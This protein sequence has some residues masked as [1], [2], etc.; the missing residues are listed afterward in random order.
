M[1]SRAMEVGLGAQRTG[2]PWSVWWGE[3][4]KIG[5]TWTETWL[6]FTPACRTVGHCMY[7]K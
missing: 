7:I 4:I 3:I 5:I 1:P 2:G 6:S